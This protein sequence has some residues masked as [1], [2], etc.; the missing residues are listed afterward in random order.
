MPPLG[1]L[2]VAAMLPPEWQLKLV[3]L[4]VERLTDEDLGWRIYVLLG[5]MIV[6]RESVREI[7]TRCTALNKTVVAGGHCSPPATKRSRK[8]STSFWA[9][10]RS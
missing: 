1:L 4:N 7:M 10:P 8:S 2:T 3:D 5:A 6:Q 9:K